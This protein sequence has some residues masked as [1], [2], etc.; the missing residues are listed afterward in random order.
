[1]FHPWLLPHFDGFMTLATPFWGNK[2]ATWT[3]G[4]EPWR[5]EHDVPDL[6]P[7]ARQLVDMTLGSDRHAR[8]RR[9][10]IAVHDE[11]L[12]EALAHIRPFAMGGYV[13]WL[14]AAAP[15]SAGEGEYEDDTAVPLPSSRPDFFFAL[16]EDV[17]YR[18]HAVVGVEAFR[19]TGFSPWTVV[20]AIHLS[21]AVDVPQISPGIAQVPSACIEALTCEHPTFRRVVD[22]LAGGRVSTSTAALPK[23]T[24]F[25]LELEVRL[26]GAPPDDLEVVIDFDA[27]DRQPPGVEVERFL[28]VFG[29]GRSPVVEDTKV[30]RFWFYGSAPDSWDGAAHQDR[31]VRLTVSAPGY[32]PRRVHARVRA[33]W[34]TWVSL[35]LQPVEA[36]AEGRGGP[37]TGGGPAVKP[38]GEGTRP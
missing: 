35:R 29:S 9:T 36:T 11:G 21:P 38:P 28:E 4:I 8:Y 22:H 14:K 5:R 18:A 23:M 3:R 19:A 20:D 16:A 25:L 1:L 6:S 15:V 17:G 34:S 27:D 37:K 30:Q 33:T 24:S 32:K 2:L 26:A 13:S 7:A 10:A 31:E 12:P